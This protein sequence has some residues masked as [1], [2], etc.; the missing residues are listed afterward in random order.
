MRYHL[1][2]RITT[3]VF[4]LEEKLNKS[5]LPFAVQLAWPST[6]LPVRDFKVISALAIKFFGLMQVLITYLGKPDSHN[7]LLVYYGMMIKTISL[8]PAQLRNSVSG[9]GAG[10]NY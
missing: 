7:H 4:C 3:S 10:G 1:I 9:G 5:T 2:G 6:A 8:K